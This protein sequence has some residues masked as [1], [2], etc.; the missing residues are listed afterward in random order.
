MSASIET[1]VGL[2]R[3]AV[4][5]AGEETAESAAAALR[6]KIRKYQ[7]LFANERGCEHFNT[8]EARRPVA[9]APRL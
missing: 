5:E 2:L 1:T 7:R 9:S 4:A 6:A 3:N 8:E